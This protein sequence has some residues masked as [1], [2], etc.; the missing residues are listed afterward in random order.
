MKNEQHVCTFTSRSEEFIDNIYKF[1]IIWKTRNTLSL[2]P[3]RDKIEH[4]SLVIYEGISNCDKNSIE[5]MWQNV[6]FR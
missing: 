2:S 3:L 6:I 5:N 4:V 1:I